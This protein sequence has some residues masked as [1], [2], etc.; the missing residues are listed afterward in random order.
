MV[1]FLTLLIPTA[2]RRKKRMK[3][4]LK[5]K[6]NVCPS[7]TNT[8]L[9]LIVDKKAKFYARKQKSGRVSTLT[10]SSSTLF[11]LSLPLARPPNR[12]TVNAGSYA[13]VLRFANATSS[14]IST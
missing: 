10:A 5:S 7:T 1:V 9:G 8:R 13:R 6:G 11:E 4:G 12:H 14:L 2:A 3:K